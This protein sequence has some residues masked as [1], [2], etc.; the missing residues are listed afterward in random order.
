MAQMETEVDKLLDQNKVW[1]GFDFSSYGKTTR[2]RQ[3]DLRKMVSLFYKKNLFF[4]R[5]LKSVEQNEQFIRRVF[6]CSLVI[7]I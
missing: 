6:S 4:A 3:R 1:A 7:V 5:C 2:K